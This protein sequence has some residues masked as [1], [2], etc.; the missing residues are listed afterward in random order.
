MPKFNPF[1]EA[2]NLLKEGDYELK[3]SSIE[4][5]LSNNQNPK[6]TF[7]YEARGEQLGEKIHKGIYNRTLT[8]NAFTFLASDM[9]NCGVFSREDLDQDRDM[10]A[11]EWA[12]FLRP[13]IGEWF[14]VSVKVKGDFNDIKFKRAESYLSGDTAPEQLFASGQMV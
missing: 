1:N 8:E 11:R 2:R 3:I 5:G 9:V 13:M 10:D 12:E 7:K 4:P 14:P 6:L